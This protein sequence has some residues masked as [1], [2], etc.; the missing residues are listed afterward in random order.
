MKAARLRETSKYIELAD[1][2]ADPS[3]PG[4][5]CFGNDEVLIWKEE[6]YALSEED[7]THVIW[8]LFYEAY[9]NNKPYP[10]T[11]EQAMEVVRVIEEAKIGTIFEK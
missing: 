9:R 6:T 2:K 1:S 10:I 8:D 11:P 5:D 4:S 3:T 7:K